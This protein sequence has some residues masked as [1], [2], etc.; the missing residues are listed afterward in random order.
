[1]SVINHKLVKQLQV[2]VGVCLTTFISFSS[3]VVFWEL[4]FVLFLLTPF[5]FLHLV[6]SLLHIK[7]LSTSSNCAFISMIYSWSVFICSYSPLRTLC[8]YFQGVLHF[9][10]FEK[11]KHTYFKCR[12]L[13]FLH[14][15][16]HEFFLHMNLLTVS[17]GKDFLVCFIIFQSSIYLPKVSQ[18]RKT[19][20][21]STPLQIPW[22]Y[23]C[24][25][26]LSVLFGLIRLLVRVDS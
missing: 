24:L 25:I 3:C 19:L 20:L 17:H 13:S 9:Y 4:P 21:L 22:I 2:R 16:I 1:M 26:Q 10:I 14:F 7:T 12:M 8:S 15:I 5:V 11:F 23:S 6:Y 18:L